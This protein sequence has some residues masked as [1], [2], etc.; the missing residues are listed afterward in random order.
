MK[1]TDLHIHTSFSDGEYSLEQIITELRRK[2]ITTFSIT[3]H[4]NIHSYDTIHNYDLSGMHYIPGVEVSSYLKVNNTKYK[5]HVLLYNYQHNL[6]HLRNLLKD[7]LEKRT[8]RIHEMLSIIE[9]NNNFR[10]T[11]EEIDAIFNQKGSVGKPQVINCLSKKLNISTNLEVYNRYL[12]N[13]KTTK[14]YRR[15]IVDVIQI[16]RQTGALVGVAHPKEIENDHN[17]DFA[18]LIPHYVN[19]GIDFIEIANSLHTNADMQR[20]L[21]LA[22]QYNLLTSGGS[23]FHGP[24]VKPSAQLGILTKDGFTHNQN[25]EDIFT[26]TKKL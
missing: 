24:F 10:F 23:D 21:T 7:I 9:F 19:L 22:N 16:A 5:T 1:L 3:D 6:N 11:E 2:E 12:K 26:L 14:E 17:V 15:N 4:D 20:Y 18:K 8:E 13:I 25:S